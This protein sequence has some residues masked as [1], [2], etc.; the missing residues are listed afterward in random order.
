MSTSHPQ[1]KSKTRAVAIAL[2]GA[3]IAALAALTG[4]A[5]ASSHSGH[6]LT[7]A[8]PS[9]AMARV[10]NTKGWLSGKTVKFHYTKNYFCRQPPHSKAGS[11]CELGANYQ[12]IPARD[13]DPL[14]V[15]VPIGFTPRSRTLQC[16]RAGHCIDH[17]HRIDLTRVFGS[18]TG[19][20]L[21]PPHSH[22]VTTAAGGDDE[23]WNV[24]VVG[25]TSQK[26]WHRIV[27]HKNYQVVQTMRNHGNSHVT[28]N[29]TT[30]LFLFFAVRS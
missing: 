5:L 21:T 1:R 16:P 8:A 11:A 13:F 29:L 27:K 7:M 28:G 19:N 6:G 15:I 3:L 24:D 10:G 20:A 26:A 12:V 9:K 22:I 2:S 30:N 4:P 17:P 14:Y 25:V 18:G 23:W